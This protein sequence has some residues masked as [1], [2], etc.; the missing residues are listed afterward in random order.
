MAAKLVEA[1][2]GYATTDSVAAYLGYTPQRI[3]Q[4]RDRLGAVEVGRNALLYPSTVVREFAKL[5]RPNRG[6]VAGPKPDER[7]TRYEPAR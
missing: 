2:S 6:R 1:I 4:L 5:P 3:R 7:G